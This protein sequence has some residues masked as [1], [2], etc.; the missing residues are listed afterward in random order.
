VD[1][2][3]SEVPSSPTKLEKKHIYI[4][5]YLCGQNPIHTQDSGTKL[6]MVIYRQNL[7]FDLNGFRVFEPAPGIE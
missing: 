6:Q 5:N 2:R 7:W 3:G 1:F 4:S